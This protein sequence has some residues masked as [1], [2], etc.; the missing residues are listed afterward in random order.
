VK[1]FYSVPDTASVREVPQPVQH[2]AIGGQA[3]R[4]GGEVVFYTMEDHYTLRTHE[5]ICGKLAEGPAIDGVIFYRLAQFFA[6][7]TI[8]VGTLRWILERGYTIAFARERIAFADVAALDRDFP[9]LATHARLHERDRDRGFL[10]TALPLVAAYE[11][12]S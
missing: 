7:G 1:A 3:S 11:R 5:V 12:A 6:A 8:D 10:R 4:L 2:L 9:L